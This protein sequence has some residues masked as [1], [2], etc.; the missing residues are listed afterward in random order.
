MKLAT[1]CFILPAS[2]YKWMSM[3]I[4]SIDVLPA[5]ETYDICFLYELQTM[6]KQQLCLYIPNIET[7]PSKK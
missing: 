5:K 4:F 3:N 2:K 7:M 1:Y 6:S